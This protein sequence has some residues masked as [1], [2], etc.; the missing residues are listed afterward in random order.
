MSRSA[1][2]YA[3]SLQLNAGPP[4]QL[5]AAAPSFGPGVAFGGDVVQLLRSLPDDGYINVRLSIGTNAVQEGQF[6]LSGF[7]NVREKVRAACKWPHAVARPG[8]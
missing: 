8:R 2:E 4:M 1:N 6:L 5:T 7:K 3:I